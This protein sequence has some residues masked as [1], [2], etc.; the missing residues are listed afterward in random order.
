[1][2]D[3]S[4]PGSHRQV[5]VPGREPNDQ[6]SCVFEFGA[7]AVRQR[8]RRPAD[9]WLAGPF[10]QRFIRH[11]QNFIAGRCACCLVG[12]RIDDRRLPEEEDCREDVPAGSGGRAAYSVIA[13]MISASSTVQSSTW[14]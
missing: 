9:K 6:N 3:R 5:T 13:P 12:R 8:L 7:E 14:N 10:P 1:M 11:R 4:E 2:P